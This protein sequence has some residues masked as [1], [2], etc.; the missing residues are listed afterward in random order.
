MVRRLS[1]KEDFNSTEQKL[2]DNGFIQWGRDLWQCQMS[3]YPEVY[4]VYDTKYNKGWFE[5][6]IDDEWV[7]IMDNLSLSELL[8][9]CDD[10][11]K[12]EF[13]RII[14]TYKY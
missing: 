8:R 14:N 6:P 10:Y 3:R 12:R 1:I 11:D 2:K 7:T 9:Q 5:F 13:E 4:A